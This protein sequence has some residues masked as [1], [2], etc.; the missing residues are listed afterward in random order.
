M[1]NTETLRHAQALK[2]LR[3]R[4][5]QIDPDNVDEFV[6]QAADQ[7][8]A[9]YDELHS[10][11]ID[12]LNDSNGER[13]ESDDHG[14]DDPASYG[15]DFADPGGTSALRA[16]T[17]GNPRNLPCPTCGAENV[18]TPADRRLGYQCNACADRA[19]FGYGY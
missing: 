18:L 13:F 6:T 2:W 16:E 11:I 3:D 5:H 12:D 19:E 8:D 4:I 7:F 15:C 9:E 10:D 17:R 1:S 14:P